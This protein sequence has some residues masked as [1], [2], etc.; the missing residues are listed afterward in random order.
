MAQE[1]GFVL[2][3][4]IASPGAQLLYNEARGGWSLFVGRSLWPHRRIPRPETA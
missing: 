1:G 2:N 3:E 4:G